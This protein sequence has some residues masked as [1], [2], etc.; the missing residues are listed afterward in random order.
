MNSCS[1]NSLTV[2]TSIDNGVKLSGLRLEFRSNQDAPE[3]TELKKILIHIHIS[4]YEKR[5]HLLS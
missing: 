5:G 1:E 4:V 3:H 2:I